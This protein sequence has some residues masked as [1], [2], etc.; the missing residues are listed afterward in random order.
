MKRFALFLGSL[1]ILPAFGEVAPIQF[2]DSLIYSDNEF[3][4]GE[5]FIDADGNIVLAS[6]VL[7]ELDAP[8]SDIVKSP[9]KISR[10]PTASRTIANRATASR[11]VPSAAGASVTSRGTSSGNSSR[12]VAA[13]TTTVSPR[14]TT[15]VRGVA[16]RTTTTGATGA[17]GAA[18]ATRTG[19]SATR[20]AA[21]RATGGAAS[22]AATATSRATIARTGVNT[23]ATKTVRT[24]GVGGVSG[25]NTTAGRGRAATTGARVSR[26]A[27]SSAT[28]LGV[29]GLLQGDTTYKTLYNPNASRVSV[30]GNVS[31]ANRVPTIR[32]AAM[33][34][35]STDAATTSIVASDTSEMD[36]LAELTDYCRAQYAACMDNYCNVL[37]DNQGRCSCSANLKNYARAEA[38]LKSAT[39]ELQEVAQKIQ[40]IGLSAREVETLFSETAAEEEM[41]TKSDTSQL[42][43]SL[44]KIKDMIIE[45]KTGT[46]SYNSTS[47]I[48]F[49]LSGLLDFTIDSTGFDL[50]SFLGG[51]TGTTGVSNQRGEDLYKTATNRCRANVLRACTAQGVDASIVTNSYDLE[52]DKEC[53]AYERSL[54]DSNDQMSATVRNAKSVL[55]K[56]RLLVEQSKNEYDMRGCINALDACMQDEFVCGS[57]YENCLDP[58]GRYIVNGAIVV[59]SQPGHVIDPSLSGVTGDVMT[60]D[61]CKINLYRTWDF[62]GQTCVP[63]DSNS[64]SQFSGSQNNAWGAG[65]NDNLAKYIENTVTG[66]VTEP[67]LNM[68]KYLQNKIGYVGTGNNSDKNYGMC[69]SVLNKCQNYTYSGTGRTAAYDPKNDVI[70]QYL[71]RIL[72]QIKSKQDE[73]LA[74]YAE[75]CVA[76]V[77][78]CL[79]QN[80]Y[81]TEEPSTWA[82]NS[83]AQTRANIAVNACRPT[84]VTCMSVNGY[85]I[86]TPSP[87]EM[88]CWVMGLTFNA[89]TPECNEYGRNNNQPQNP[90]A[91]TYT[92]TYQCGTGCLGTTSSWTSTVNSAT[93]VT[94]D[95]AACADATQS[96]S[97]YKVNGQ[98]QT[99]NRIAITGNTTVTVSCTNNSGGDN[100]S[101]TFNKIQLQDVE[102]YE[103]GG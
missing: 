63:T 102:S 79:A 37:D 7:D 43:T 9:L 21:T 83:T 61:V 100:T 86:N 13:R 96:V 53:V 41:K 90:T 46:T 17:T 29:N 42:K 59:G 4:D 55:Q 82:D 66:A 76:D 73:I 31:V 49:D 71:A 87:Q 78:S 6:D 32:M 70:K 69:I 34:G 56:A 81:P 14:A 22:S 88:N 93:S 33:G 68:S 25:A 77:T 94:L 50:S 57:D 54:N 2:D 10:Q 97:S 72:V 75:S 47:G 1:L 52:I 80:N 38:A 15:N 5:Y 99:Q 65:A 19:T 12:A 58:S 44:D 74:D 67:S 8:D 51:L 11:T 84:I 30:R 36:D 45:V 92:L 48:S 40:Y 3:I 28:T 95:G 24:A 18:G 85:S 60:S 20:A 89:L 35:L 103:T 64:N 91:N 98:T 16:T 62:D 39:E 23:A 26:A 27:T 101:N